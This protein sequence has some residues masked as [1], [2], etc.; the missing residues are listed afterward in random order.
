MKSKTI[1]I[2]AGVAGLTIAS[3]IPNDDYIIL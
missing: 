2:G 3:K 1:I